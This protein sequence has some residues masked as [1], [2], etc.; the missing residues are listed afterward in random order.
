MDKNKIMFQDPG[1]S[2]TVNLNLEKES[3][4]SEAAKALQKELNTNNPPILF[5]YLNK[6]AVDELKNR[7]I[8]E[9]ERVDLPDDVTI[10]YVINNLRDPRLPIYFHAM[11]IPEEKLYELRTLRFKQSGYNI[12]K[13]KES[14]VLI[15]GA[16]LLGTEVA[17]NLATVGVGN[18]SIIDNGYIDWTNIYRQSLFSKEDVYKKK[19]DVVKSRLLKLG[20]VN[21]NPIHLELPSWLS[22]MT[23]E[24]VKKNI[25]I[26]NIAVE[27]ADIVIGVLDKF[28]PRAVLQFLCLV[29]SRPYV[30]AALQGDMGYVRIFDENAID[31][32]YCCGIPDP[33]ENKWADGGVC[34]LSSLE[35]QKIISSLASKLVVD[36]LEEREFQ[37][38]KVNYNARTMKIETA[39][40]TKTSSCTLC[41]DSGVLKSFQGNVVGAIEEYLFNYQEE[42]L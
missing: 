37:A 7:T 9:G 28:S 40:Y 30:V 32:C 39:T 4:I 25:D 10:S 12:S 14:K 16:G 11:E 33:R 29:K 42:N 35:S 23:G 17:I 1:T 6:S 5:A 8:V 26:L 21:V 18:I 19:V 31:G 24:E 2:Q 41:G 15:V 13:L 36:K 38:N 3:K 20:G 22:I 27:E 34:T